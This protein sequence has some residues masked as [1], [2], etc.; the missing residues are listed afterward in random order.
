MILYTGTHFLPSG[1]VSLTSLVSRSLKARVHPVILSC[2]KLLRASAHMI[3]AKEQL[4]FNLSFSCIHEVILF[5]VIAVVLLSCKA[6]G[7]PC[8]QWLTCVLVNK[9][10][11]I[12]EGEEWRYMQHECV[13]RQTKHSFALSFC[14]Q[15]YWRSL[16]ISIF[17]RAEEFGDGEFLKQFWEYY[18]DSHFRKQILV[19]ACK[20]PWRPEIQV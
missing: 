6:L 4:W 15:W 16:A 18:S 8:Q 5:V 3:L 10:A 13:H 7:I 9:Y 20:S 14:S 17:H 1:R 11:W 19:L 2:S 12:N